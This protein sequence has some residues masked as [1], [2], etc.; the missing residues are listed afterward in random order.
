VIFYSSQFTLWKPV[1]DLTN[2]WVQW[3]V[4]LVLEFLW[5][6]LTFLLHAENCPRYGIGVAV[7]IF[8]ALFDRKSE[9]SHVQ[10]RL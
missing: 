1:R 7:D 6:M 9:Q 8:S 3:M 2:N 10:H 5:L 4:I